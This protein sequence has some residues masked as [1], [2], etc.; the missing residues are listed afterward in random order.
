MEITTIDFTEQKETE[1]TCF[2]E[3]ACLALDET[4]TL[5]PLTSLAAWNPV[6]S[7]FQTHWGLINNPYLSYNGLYT[8]TK[9]SRKFLGLN[10]VALLSE[11][12]SLL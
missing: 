5:P 6:S 10:A 8:F 1:S 4:N 9:K 12:D 7:K 3:Y 11:R 2:E